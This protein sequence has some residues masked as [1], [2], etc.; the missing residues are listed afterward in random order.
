M[1]NLPED[2]LNIIYKKIFTNNVLPLIKK[3]STLCLLCCVHGFPCIN[4][5]E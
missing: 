1:N 2:I 5:A 3:K 4:C